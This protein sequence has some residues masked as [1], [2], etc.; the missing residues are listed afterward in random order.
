MYKK[1]SSKQNAT[2]RKSETPYD[3]CFN[4]DMYLKLFL[5]AIA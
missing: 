5:S 1:H 2:I 3:Y 4:T